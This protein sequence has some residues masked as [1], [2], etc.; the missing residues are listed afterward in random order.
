MRSAI[1]PLEA[2]EPVRDLDGSRS[3]LRGRI[4]FDGGDV[5]IREFEWDAAGWVMPDSDHFY[6]SRL[7]VPLK[8]DQT[9]RWHHPGHERPLTV[10]QFGVNDPS[11][12]MMIAHGPGN[13][14][15]LICRIAIARFR[16]M[17]GS[18]AW[19]SEWAMRGLGSE[20]PFFKAL[21]DRLTGEVLRPS[22]DSPAFVEALLTAFAI[23]LY[24][25]VRR[26]A[27]AVE[28][29]GL[30]D[31]QLNRIRGLVETGGS[32]LTSAEIAR[33]CGVSVR[34]LARAFRSSQGMTLH[35]YI[36]QVRLAKA[37]TMLTESEKPLKVVAAEAG[38]ASASHFS[39]SF[40]SAI[41]CSPSEYRTHVRLATESPRN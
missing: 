4:D 29:G 9:I 21:L 5:E 2:I 34:H 6:I 13:A 24:R 35:D 12:P 27:R 32:R 26:E 39:A 25:E 37:R 18:E 41:G 1:A 36:A 7:M 3:T 8:G 19:P 16:A 10:A 14:C 22:P 23:E 31:W 40:R 11:T 15:F 33:R 17:T 28:Q 38:F 20:G 30:A